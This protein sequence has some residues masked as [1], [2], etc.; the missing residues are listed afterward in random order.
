MIDISQIYRRIEN[1][2]TMSAETFDLDVVFANASKL[3]EKYK[4][5]YDPACPVPSDDD[6]ADRVFQAG[7]DF[8][9]ETGVYCPDRSSV[10]WFTRD[11]VLEAI[12]NSRGRCIMGEGKDR[13]EW[14][15]RL[16]DSNTNPWYHVG[17]GIVNTDEHIIFNLARSYAQIEQANSVSVPALEKIDGIPISSGTPTEILGAIRGIKIARDALCHAG[18]PGLAIGNCI[19]T[20]GTAIA[21]IAASSPQFGLRSSDGWLVG[22]LAEMKVD[23]GALNKAAYLSSW[24]ANIC[25]ESGPL[26]GGYAG[27]PAGV[28]VLNVAYR[29]IGLLVLNCDYHLTF[30]IHIAKS[31]STTR[32]VLWCASVSAQAISRNT[33][34]LVWSLGYMAAGPMTKQFFYETA[35]YMASVIPSGVSAQTTHPAR[36]LLNDYITPMEMKGSVEINEACVGMSRSQGNELVK[37][38]LSKYEDK[39]DNAPVGKRYQDCYDINSGL[40]SQEHV[41]L[42]SEVKEELIAMGFRLKYG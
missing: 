27:G 4:I 42:Y 21:T 24:G 33:K 39:I 16:P 1:G 18:R 7:V 31:C 12:E 10:I 19:S 20:A 22:V 11:E 35:A 13:F 3:C 2:S 28:A 38:L 23:M 9:V 29:L 25:C 6:L 26:V 36:A 17:T 37:E 40:P 14:T 30:P 34:E 41:D 32:E 5:T 15:P 8:V